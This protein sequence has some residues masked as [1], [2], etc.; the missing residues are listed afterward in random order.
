MTEMKLQQK[1]PVE[2]HR[3][4]DGIHIQHTDVAEIQ[5]TQHEATETNSRNVS[6]LHPGAGGGSR[7]C[8]RSLHSSSQTSTFNDSSPKNVSKVKFVFSSFYKI[9]DVL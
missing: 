5:H 7:S 9:C 3:E 8:L 6:D 2:E 4:S 1:E